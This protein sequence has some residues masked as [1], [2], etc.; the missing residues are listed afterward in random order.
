M[1]RLYSSAA[2]GIGEGETGIIGAT[3]PSQIAAEEEV[4][5]FIRKIE[6]LCELFAERASAVDTGGPGNDLIRD[7]IRRLADLRFFGARAP[8]EFGGLGLPD[9]VTREA[10]ERM[11]ATCGATAFAQQQLHG[12]PGFVS[13]SQD[14]A[15][16]RELMPNLIAGEILSGVAFSH[17]R[18]PGPPVLSAEPVKGGYK[19]FGEA[20]WVSDWRMLDSFILGA[21]VVGTGEMLFCYVDIKDAGSSMIPSPPMQLA[22]MT[23]VDTVSVKIDGL[24]VEERYV[25]QKR[26][27]DHMKNSDFRSITG[28]CVMPLGCARGSAEYLATLGKEQATEASEQFF[29]EI[30]HCREESHYWTGARADDAEYRE[31]ALRVRATS[32]SI[33][34]RAAE[35][36]IAASG[37]RAHLLTHPA[38]RRLRE[39]GFYATMAQT[40]DT[41]SALMEI[42]SHA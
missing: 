19:L 15:L 14:E 34:L 2:R 3:M 41:Q 30:N 31:N 17:L 10:T 26:A 7:N 37:G 42:L 35:T 33:A 9:L 21:T 22:V 40:S 28:H 27:A 38:Q 25:L 8:Y 20:P 1:A 4:H 12:G 24:L 16:K 18:R 29:R 5:P 13:G 6:T 36:A 23:A 32:I 11:A 39:A